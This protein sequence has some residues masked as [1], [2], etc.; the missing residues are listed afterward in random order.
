MEVYVGYGITGLSYAI[1]P[2]TEGNLQW[3]GNSSIGI[4][5]GDWKN[6][7]VH[8]GG[9]H[10]FGKLLDEYHYNDSPNYTSESIESQAWEVPLGLN[11]TTD[12]N[13]TKGSVYWKHLLNDSQ[14]PPQAFSKE[15]WAIRVVSGTLKL[16]VVWMI[17]VY[18]SIQYRVS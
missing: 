5:T 7:F 8:E 14:Y 10:G 4:S 15:G 12:F 16:Q 6:V 11:L 9:G 13:N 2:L 3:S 1:I 17:T 18:I